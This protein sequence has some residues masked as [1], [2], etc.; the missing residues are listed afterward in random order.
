[1]GAFGSCLLEIYGFR[2]IDVEKLMFYCDI[3]FYNSAVYLSSHWWNLD[4]Q[5]EKEM[6]I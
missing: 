6:F 4:V 5:L 3:T 2:D 1:M